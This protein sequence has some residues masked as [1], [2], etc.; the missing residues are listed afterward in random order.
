M[1]LLRAVQANGLDSQ[2]AAYKRSYR[3]GDDATIRFGR[4]CAIPGARQLLADGRPVVLGSRAFDLLMVLLNARGTVVAK[5]VIVDQVWPS[6]AVE[7]SNLRFQIASLRRAL[8]PDRDIIKTV[9]GRGYIL[10]VDIDGQLQDLAISRPPNP[11]Q[12]AKPSSRARPKGAEAGVVVIDD[13]RD[14]REALTGFL[15]STGLRTEAYGSVEA[16]QDSGRPFPP[17]CLVLDVWLPGQS[18]LEFQ[19]ELAERHVN[20]PI[21]FISG[22]ADVPMSVR[23]MKAGAI[24]FLTKPVHHEVLLNAIHLAMGRR[25]RRG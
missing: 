21:I 25:G 17:G 22:H 11:A 10:A 9:S 14:V 8:G 6:T 3:P 4:F 5:D 13:D 18:G 15:Q 23:A 2:V 16:F 1:R 24:E 7:E 20:L 19:A 12:P